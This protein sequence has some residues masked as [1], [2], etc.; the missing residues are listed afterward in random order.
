[1]IKRVFIQIICL[2]I[3]SLTGNAQLLNKDSLLKSLPSAKEDTNKV[4]LYFT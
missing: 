3:I 4:K 2:L 1:M